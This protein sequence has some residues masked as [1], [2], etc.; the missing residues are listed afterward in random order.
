MTTVATRATA[1]EVGAAV[2]DGGVPRDGEGR[3]RLVLEQIDSVAGV[4]PQEVIGP[5]ARLAER[6]G[7][8]ATEEIS[9]HV[10]L[11]HLEF[12]GANALR[13]FLNRHR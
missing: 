2:A 13:G 5:R 8:G 12:T 6:V 10:H 1:E 4:V 9:L 11:Q 7:V 3:A